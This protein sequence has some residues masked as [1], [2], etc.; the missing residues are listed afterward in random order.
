MLS[1]QRCQSDRLSTKLLPDQMIA[2]R[3]LVTFVE[4]QVDRLQHTIETRRQ[5]IARWYFEWNMFVAD[6][7]FRS[8]QTLRDGR[9]A[10]EKSFADFRGAECA[11]SFQG[12]RRLIFCGQRRMATR[13]H[14]SQATVPNLV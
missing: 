6:L 11:Q 12:Q 7:L 2:A 14:Q 5:R 1:E 8:G 3:C 13:K 4:K 9:F 10:R